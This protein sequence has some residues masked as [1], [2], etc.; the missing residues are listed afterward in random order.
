MLKLRVKKKAAPRG[1]TTSGYLGVGAINRQVHRK[2]I[3]SP[4][5]AYLPLDKK[6]Q[7]PHILLETFQYHIMLSSR[8]QITGHG[9]TFS[10]GVVFGDMF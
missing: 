3:P 10:G 5:R 2:G 6:Q 4:A 7:H 1:L 8:A 9:A